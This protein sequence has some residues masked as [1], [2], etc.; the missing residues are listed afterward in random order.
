MD[1]FNVQISHRPTRNYTD[2]IFLFNLNLEPY[3]WGRWPK[4]V[5]PERRTYDIISINRDFATM[6]L[7]PQEIGYLDSG[8]I[9]SSLVLL[10]SIFCGSLFHPGHRN[11]QSN[12]H[13]TAPFRGS[14]I[15]AALLAKKTAS[16]IKK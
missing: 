3:V 8:I 5:V 4:G 13:K 1:M 14:F 11:G 9:P 15:N 2:F 6:K 10:H 7:N 16:L 12:H